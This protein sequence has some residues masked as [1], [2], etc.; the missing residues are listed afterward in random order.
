MNVE[1]PFASNYSDLS[2]EEGNQYEF[3]CERCGNGYKST[4]KNATI[5]NIGSKATK[6]LG[7]MFGGKL[8]KVASSADAALHNVADSKV[9]E[10]AF[11]SAVDEVQRRFHRC[12]IC[13]DWVCE[14][15]CWDDQYG[16]CTT[17]AAEQ[18]NQEQAGVEAAA[19][20]QP[21]QVAEAA[22]AVAAAFTGVI[23]QAQTVNA[24][25]SCGAQ[26]AAGAKFCPE[27]GH[28]LNVNL[29]CPKCGAESPSGTKFCPECGTAMVGA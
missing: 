15:K 20:A 9:T 18:R 5:T 27:C 12:N 2:T 22:Q 13:R 7:G 24:C 4:F 25:P 19:A 8:S 21:E 16:L 17:C 28:A 11:S 26:H 6:S 14:E 23:T 29:A 10:K 3:F 1:V